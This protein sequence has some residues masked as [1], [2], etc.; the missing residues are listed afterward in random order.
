M[1]QTHAVDG[2]K[3]HLHGHGVREKPVA[4]HISEAE[5]GVNATL[6]DLIDPHAHHSHGPNVALSDTHQT[7]TMISPGGRSAKVDVWA[8]HWSPKRFAVSAE[9]VLSRVAMRSAQSEPLAPPAW[10]LSSR[11]RCATAEIALLL[12]SG[13]YLGSVC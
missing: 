4:H 6:H 11:L 8:A 7:L 12:S 2:S 1:G 9:L 3:T 10:T 5:D 13:P